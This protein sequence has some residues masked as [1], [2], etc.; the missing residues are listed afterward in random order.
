M[1]S[2]TSERAASGA[3]P[4][5]GSVTLVEKFQAR[6]DVSHR[7]RLSSQLSSNQG[8]PVTPARC[9]SEITSPG[10]VAAMERP[11][12]ASDAVHAHAGESR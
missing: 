4:G 8:S 11:S 5:G 7:V 10:T 2:N 1:P 3:A 6:S 9:R 12:D